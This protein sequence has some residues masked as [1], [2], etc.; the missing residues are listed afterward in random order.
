MDIFV[1]S[2]RLLLSAI[3]GLYLE[4][5]NNSKF[6]YRVTITIANLKFVYVLVIRV[7]QYCHIVRVCFMFLFKQFS[8]LFGVYTKTTKSSKLNISIGKNK[9][10]YVVFVYV[11]VNIQSGKFR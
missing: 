2:R 5:E 10:S 11:L 3:V 7:C 4:L 9:E 1:I 6:V 8:C